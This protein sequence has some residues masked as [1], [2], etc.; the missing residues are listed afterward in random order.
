MASRMC[1]MAQAVLRTASRQ[2]DNGARLRHIRCRFDRWGILESV[3]L[4]SQTLS[5]C[6]HLRRERL[7]RSTPPT[8]PST[9][10]FK[11]RRLLAAK[12]PAR[13]ARF[14]CVNARPTDVDAGSCE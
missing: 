10:R 4:S 3:W 1:V 12:S 9:P 14:A 6:A 2:E 8:T 5:I 7:S 13:S 11:D